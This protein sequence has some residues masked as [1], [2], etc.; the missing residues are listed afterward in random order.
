[1]KKSVL[2]IIAL[3]G[4]A[5]I[6]AINMANKQETTTEEMAT[7]E[8]SVP[9]DNTVSPQP[10]G[11]PAAAPTDQPA[12]ATFQAPDGTATTVT[13]TPETPQATPDDAAPAAGAG[14]Q[15]S[16]KMDE[17]QTK[18]YDVDVDTNKPSEENKQ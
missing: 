14:N 4:L 11:S 16:E 18:S 13:V 9:A 5:V 12:S 10:M 8:Q 7:T 17:I 2:F 1:M 15:A 6:A 3:A